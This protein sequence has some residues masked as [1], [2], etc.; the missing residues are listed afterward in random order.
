MSR[1]K[2]IYIY[3]S[4]VCAPLVYT[5]KKLFKKTYARDTRV[6]FNNSMSH[7]IL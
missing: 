6:L 1:M 7:E 2:I 5:F 4:F 3:K